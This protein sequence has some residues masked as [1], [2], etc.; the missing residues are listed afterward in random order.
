MNRIELPS[1]TR[2]FDP[3]MLVVEKGKATVAG[4]YDTFGAPG[5][6]LVGVLA[7]RVLVGQDEG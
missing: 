6:K 3:R 4:N 7:L 5:V 2:G 1:D